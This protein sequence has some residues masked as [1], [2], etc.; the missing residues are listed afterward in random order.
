MSCDVAGMRIA[1]ATVLLLASAT[2]QAATINNDLAFACADLGDQLRIDRVIAARDQE[3][4]T[5]LIEEGF[6]AK[7]CMN[8]P[9]GLGVRV[10]ERVGKFSCVAKLGS[11]GRCLW[12]RSLL[13]DR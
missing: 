2:A 5:R 13:V 1:L 12:L 9:K 3:A 8:L 4:V 10:E 11:T 7:R 6:R